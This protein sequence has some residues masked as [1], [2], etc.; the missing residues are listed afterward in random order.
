MEKKSLFIVKGRI[1]KMNHC[2]NEKYLRYGALHFLPLEEIA[3]YEY[4]RM[5]DDVFS[6]NKITVIGNHKA[7]VKR[8]KR[9]HIRFLEN[10]EL[11]E[12]KNPTEKTIEYVKRHKILTFE[13]ESI[14]CDRVQK[15]LE[16]IKSKGIVEIKEEKI[17]DE[18]F[19][20]A[21]NFVSKIQRLL[22]DKKYE[23]FINNSFSFP[24]HSLRWKNEGK[25]E[26]KI[27][28][29]FL[30]ENFNEIFTEKTINQIIDTDLDTIYPC[31]YMLI[32]GSLSIW[33]SNKKDFK[34][35]TVQTL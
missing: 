2:G 13:K 16:H 32:V 1:K 26:E 35:Y 4:G 12:L 15:V 23:E 11:F 14:T 5:E 29:E 27:Y 30:A 28:A 3:L 10:L 9:I 8:T 6:H 17:E 31:G 34:I 19:L 20:K 18:L 33:I 24:L 21:Q 22:I 7:G 25:I